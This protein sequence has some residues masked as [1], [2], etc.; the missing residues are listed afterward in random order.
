VAVSKETAAALAAKYPHLAARAA[1]AVALAVEEQTA[2]VRGQRVVLARF[3][4][5]LIPDVGSPGGQTVAL[6]EPHAA[7][8]VA[9]APVEAK[10][11]PAAVAE[12]SA[13]VSTSEAETP[14]PVPMPAPAAHHE[15]PSRFEPHHS[16]GKS[17]R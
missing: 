13:P 10:A 1:D 16:G 9:V 15:Q 6:D 5:Y 11:A 17:K 2:I 3:R 7:P 12:A 8:A 4:K 14:V